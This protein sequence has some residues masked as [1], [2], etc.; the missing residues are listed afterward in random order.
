MLHI[1]I[2]TWACIPHATVRRWE[3]GSTIGL[4]ETRED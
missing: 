3:L 2:V 1:G 4:F